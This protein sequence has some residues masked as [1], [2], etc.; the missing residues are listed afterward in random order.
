MPGESCAMHSQ[1]MQHDNETKTFGGARDQC[2]FNSCCP[3]GRRSAAIKEHDSFQGLIQY[4]VKT[5]NKNELSR[6]Q[7]TTTINKKHDAF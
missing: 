3:S 1:W 4:R 5:D 7:S 2:G 6:P